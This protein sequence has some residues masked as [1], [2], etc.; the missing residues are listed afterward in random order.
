MEARPAKSIFKLLRAEEYT[1]QEVAELLEI[2]EHIVQN[3]VFEGDLP[4]QVVG[5]DII[6][7]RQQDVIAWF[8]ARYGTDRVVP[9][10]SGDR[11]RHG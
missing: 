3:A 8:N 2:G 5:H 11:E 10:D 9:Q 7:I 4:A 1:P 6:S